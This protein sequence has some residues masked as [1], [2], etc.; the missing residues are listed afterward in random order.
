MSLSLPR[1]QN[2]C[3]S[4]RFLF[5]IAL[6]SV[7]GYACAG[8]RRPQGT[9]MDERCGLPFWTVVWIKHVGERKAGFGFQK[10]TAGAKRFD[11]CPN[12]RY[13]LQCQACDTLPKVGDA[14]LI[15][16]SEERS[17]FSCSVRDSHT[18]YTSREWFSY[19]WRILSAE[20]A[21]AWESIYD[22]ETSEV[23]QIREME[24]RPASI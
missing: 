4:T 8:L 16:V 24:K 15:F 9:M 20:E 2:W 7:I 19:D 23:R 10:I 1:V 18:G 6:K 22:P 21:T 11:S 5:F 14:V 12:V 17:S 13:S 3:S